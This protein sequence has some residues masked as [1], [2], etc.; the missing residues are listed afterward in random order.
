M[1]SGL[2]PKVSAW[3]GERRKIRWKKLLDGNEV[4][5][6]DAAGAPVASSSSESQQQKVKETL[7]GNVKVRM[8]EAVC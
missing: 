8:G 6:F 2:V 5:R 1:T 7:S 3:S 4:T